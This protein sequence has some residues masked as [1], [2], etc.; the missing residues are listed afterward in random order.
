VAILPIKIMGT[1]ILRERAREVGEVTDE[2]RKLVA[3]MID[4]M[5][6]A[7]GVGLAAPQVGVPVRI[8]VWEVDDEHG[9]LIDP[10]IVERSEDMVDGEEGCLSI[11]GLLYEVTR[12]DRVVVEAKDQDGR[13]IRIEAV[14]FKA[15][16]FQHEIDHLD[17]VLF[18]DRLP[19]EL[20]AQAIT[21]WR[22]LILSPQGV[23]PYGRS[24]AEVAPESP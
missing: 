12:S 8:F 16:V 18:I 15:R 20:R 9:A 21:E 14:D 6:D 7:P 10:V 11:P 3:D 19:D 23:V 13:P 5:R 4:T 2:H 1:P 22:D 17:G 24:T